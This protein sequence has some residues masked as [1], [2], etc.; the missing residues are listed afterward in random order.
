MS[1]DLHVDTARPLVVKALN[2]VEEKIY[3]RAGEEKPGW[4][5]SYPGTGSYVVGESEARRDDCFKRMATV[6]LLLSL[7]FT[8]YELDW[9]EVKMAADARRAWVL[10]RHRVKTET[11]LLYASS[12]PYAGLKKFIYRV[13]CKFNQN[14]GS[15]YI[16]SFV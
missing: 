5:M 9:D 15:Y 6:D 14:S 12:D 4:S 8:G 7:P 11:G 16:F 3:W 2:W 1:R 13:S 10:A